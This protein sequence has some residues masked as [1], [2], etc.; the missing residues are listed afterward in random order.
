MDK[1]TFKTI[2]SKIYNSLKKEGVKIPNSKLLE[3]ISQALGYKNYNTFLGME[4]KKQHIQDNNENLKRIIVELEENTPENFINNIYILIKESIINIK[5]IQIVK[6]DKLF[7]IDFINT[8]FTKI[9]ITN[10]SYILSGNFHLYKERKYIK[11]LYVEIREYFKETR[12]ILSENCLATKDDVDFVLSKMFGS[13]FYKYLTV[14]KG[15]NDTIIIYIHENINQD[16][17]NKI[18]NIFKTNT[19]VLIK[20]IDSPVVTLNVE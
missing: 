9:Q 3:I 8:D 2:S 20:R 5:N 1:D 7:I 16:I 11:D 18:Q 19:N 6:K 13:G 17:E 10:I 14:A 4:T 12:K 15:V